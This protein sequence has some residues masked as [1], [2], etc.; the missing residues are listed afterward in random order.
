MAALWEDPRGRPCLWLVVGQLRRKLLGRSGQM[1]GWHYT[2]PSMNCDAFGSNCSGNV[3]NWVDPDI[4]KL[5]TIRKDGYGAGIRR[6]FRPSFAMELRLLTNFAALA[7]HTRR[8]HHPQLAVPHSDLRRSSEA[9]RGRGSIR[10]QNN[11]YPSC[12]GRYDA[13]PQ[14]GSEPEQLLGCGHR[15]TFEMAAR[16][17]PAGHLRRAVGQP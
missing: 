17:R 12:Q 9:I 10:P 15:V 4:W 3:G 5:D 13:G 8:V 16:C 11:N 1:S 2:D 7:Q 14:P 6:R